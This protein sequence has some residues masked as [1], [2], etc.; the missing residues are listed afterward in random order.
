MSDYGTN[1][2]T[3]I[4]PRGVNRVRNYK[5][6]AEKKTIDDVL[7]ELD[8]EVGERELL[9]NGAVTSLQTE[10]KHGDK[11]VLSPKKPSGA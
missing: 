3:V 5:W 6:E 10:V 1:T 11:I 7:T 4:D 8:I 9:L 2:V